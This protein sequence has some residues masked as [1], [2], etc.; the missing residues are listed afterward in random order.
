[1]IQNYKEPY[2]IW[3]RDREEL[4]KLRDQG[5]TIRQIAEK[6]HVSTQ[7][8]WARLKKHKESKI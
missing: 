7:S 8:V 4:A 3:A 1:M 2:K 6:L 5:M